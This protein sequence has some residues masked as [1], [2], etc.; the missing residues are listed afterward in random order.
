M[1]YS[2]LWPH[3]LVF[4]DAILLD[5]NTLVEDLK[6]LTYGRYAEST[7]ILKEGKSIAFHCVCYVTVQQLLVIAECVTGDS[8]YAYEALN[9]FYMC[10]WLPAGV[11]TICVSC[12]NCFNLRCKLHQFLLFQPIEF[13]LFQPIELY[14]IY[15][16]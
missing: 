12:R 10:V 14:F 9:Q 6:S 7:V 3:Q 1:Y 13:L 5:N 8:V 15:H 11:E 4:L 2:D 16:D